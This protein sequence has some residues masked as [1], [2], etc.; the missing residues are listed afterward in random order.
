MF[1]KITYFLNTGDY[2][3]AQLILKRYSHALPTYIYEILETRLSFPTAQV[4]SPPAFVSDEDLQ[5]M[6]YASLF[7]SDA[8]SFMKKYKKI[9]RTPFFLPLAS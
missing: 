1:C 2:K 3:R 6:K 7:T 5:G 4:S 8:H 9:L